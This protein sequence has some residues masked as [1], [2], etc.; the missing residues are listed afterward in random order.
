MKKKNQEEQAKKGASGENKT[1]GDESK[2]HTPDQKALHDLAEK[3][4]R[5]GV[6]NPDADTLLEWGKEYN[7]PARD[8]RGKPNHWK[9]GDDHI[10][11]GKEHIPINEEID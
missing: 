4:N 2:R 3:A 1:A 10:H 6:T 5:T 11:I 8:D 9:Y 7:M